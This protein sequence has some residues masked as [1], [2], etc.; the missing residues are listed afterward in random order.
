MATA[1]E[2]NRGQGYER[3]LTGRAQKVRPYHVALP[4]N[5]VEQALA[6]GDVIEGL[7]ARGEAHPRDPSM[8]VRSHRAREISTTDSEVDVIYAT[9]NVS[10]FQYSAPDFEA[11][12]QFL[13]SVSFENVVSVQI[14]FAFRR[15]ITVSAGGSE[16]TKTIWDVG[17]RQY[18]EKRTVTR[19]EWELTNP[20]LSDI[21]AFET[22]QNFIHDI[23]GYLYLFRPASITPKGGSQFGA[24]YRVV[25]SWTYDD[26]TRKLASRDL[27]KY[28]MPGDTGFPIS[29]APIAGYM[30][31]Q[32]N[33]LEVLKSDDPEAAPPTLIQVPDYYADAPNSWTTLPGVPNL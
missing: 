32:Y 13:W 18:E 10:R 30:R 2:I 29:P 25:A 23:G 14:P 31:D 15:R 33:S 6:A 26:G 4:I 11:S 8:I 19:V 7:P 27:S 28:L 9:G 3:D 17:F 21:V 16:V 1:T 5:D 20:T 12:N 24:A 22:Q